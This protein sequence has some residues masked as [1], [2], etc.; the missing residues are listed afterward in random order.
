[1]LS[2]LGIPIAPVS[3]HYTFVVLNQSIHGPREAIQPFRFGPS[4]QRAP[5]HTST[6]VSEK[7]VSLSVLSQFKENKMVAQPLR[8]V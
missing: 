8:R 4:L 1:M 6:G 7:E 3:P 5:T 2:S